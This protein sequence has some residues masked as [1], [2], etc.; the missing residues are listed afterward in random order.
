MSCTISKKNYRLDLKTQWKAKDATRVQTNWKLNNLLNSQWQNYDF[1]HANRRSTRHNKA[2]YNFSSATLIIKHSHSFS[3]TW[4]FLMYI[5]KIFLQLK[6]Q[7]N[8]QFLYTEV[9]AATLTSL[10]FVLLHLDLVKAGK[11]EINNSAAKPL[12]TL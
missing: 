6:K 2:F 9:S 8:V 4:S 1:F 12:R 11:R 7:R 3:P 10:V 5:F